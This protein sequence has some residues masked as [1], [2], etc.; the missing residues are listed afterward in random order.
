MNVS[1]LHITCIHLV[2]RCGAHLPALVLRFRIPSFLLLKRMQ[3][4]LSTWFLLPRGEHV[5]HG[6]PGE[7]LLISAR[8]PAHFEPLESAAL[9]LFGANGGGKGGG[10]AFG[11]LQLDVKSSPQ[12]GA[13]RG[14]FKAGERGKG[15]S[16]EL[17]WVLAHAMQT[18]ER[19]AIGFNN[20]CSSTFTGRHGGGDR[21][22]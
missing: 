11:F 21:A 6:V 7:R 15:D 13:A 2:A 22:G 14:P 18:S 8:C 19:L 9:H 1:L 5:P 17:P 12:R 3:E 20:A 16:G 4:H 10:A